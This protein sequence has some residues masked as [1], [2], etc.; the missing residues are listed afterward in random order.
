M[1]GRKGKENEQRKAESGRR[2]KKYIRNKMKERKLKESRKFINLWILKSTSAW[3][4]VFN[5][6]KERLHLP[7]ELD[8]IS[9][10]IN[11]KS[12]REVCPFQIQ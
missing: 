2:R 7:N 9:E 12:C 1:D 5:P 10:E 6:T 8:D 3:R 4:F 11:Y